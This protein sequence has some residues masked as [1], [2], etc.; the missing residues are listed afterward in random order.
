MR[1]LRETAWTP[2]EEQ[3]T[4][5]NIAQFMSKHG[6]GSYADLRAAWTADAA[7]FWGTMADELGIHWLERP[8]ATLDARVASPGCWFPGGITNVVS[9]CVDRH[10][11]EL[12]AYVREG[13]E[14]DVDR[15]TFGELS[16]LVSRI[17]GALRSLGVSR[18][19]RVG[20]Y[21][22]LTPEAYAC[23]YACAKLGAV[24]VPMFSG[25]GVAAIAARLQDAGASVLITADAFVRRGKVIPMREIAEAAARESGVEQLL[26]WPRLRE[27]N[28]DA[29][30]A[31]DPSAR[32]SR[33]PPTIPS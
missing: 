6:L 2:S 5:A 11:P 10:D 14:G 3:R 17:A 4:G 29:L 33:S 9:S 8:H 28:W 20:L 21:L 13:E 12:L 32:R 30:L 23:M 18:D 26:V 22:P 16:D 25:F 1:S 24:A 19:D 27:G 31:A 7:W 15:M